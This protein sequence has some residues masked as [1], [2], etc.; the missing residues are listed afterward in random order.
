MLEILFMIMSPLMILLSGL[1]SSVTKESNR[2]PEDMLEMQAIRMR[3][4]I[5]VLLLHM[6]I[7]MMG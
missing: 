4:V 1:R 3:I 2:S 5:V 7:V 6:R